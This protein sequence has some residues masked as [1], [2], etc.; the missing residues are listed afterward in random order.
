MKKLSL[1]FSKK[2]PQLLSCQPNT[3]S[4]PRYSNSVI[5][6]YGIENGDRNLNYG[7]ISLREECRSDTWRYFKRAL[8]Q[9]DGRGNRRKS[10][11]ASPKRTKRTVNHGQPSASS[12]AVA[13][14]VVAASLSSYQAFINRSA[15]KSRGAAG[16]EMFVR[17]AK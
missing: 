8:N 13:V 2:N 15:P 3:I 5:E 11:R 16:L 17:I 14:V 12:R 7:I 9:N 4:S 1:I 6:R 10:R